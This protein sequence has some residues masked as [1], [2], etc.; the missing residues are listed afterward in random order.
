MSQEDASDAS[1]ANNSQAGEVQKEAQKEALKRRRGNGP[2]RKD[3][4]KIT[5]YNCNKKGY[6][7]K[8]CIETKDSR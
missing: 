7:A 1:E 3:V 6:Y 4:F 8:Y 5:C 2:N